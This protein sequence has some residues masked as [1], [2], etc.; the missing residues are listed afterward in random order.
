MGL[1]L[2]DS[3]P[4]MASTIFGPN[5]G[6]AKNNIVPDGNKP[7]VKGQR[8]TKGMNLLKWGNKNLRNTDKALLILQ[9][10]RERESVCVCV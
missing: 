9:R 5:N 1:V 2:H 10:E 3:R 6:C 7:C 8:L 4:L